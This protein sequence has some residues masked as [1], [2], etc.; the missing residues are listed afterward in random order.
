[1]AGPSQQPNF[2]FSLNDSNAQNLGLNQ[3]LEV[4]STPKSIAQ[5]QT[6]TKKKRKLTSEV[7]KRFELVEIKIPLETS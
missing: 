6:S 7:W 2:D 4:E 3:D 5:R 1:M